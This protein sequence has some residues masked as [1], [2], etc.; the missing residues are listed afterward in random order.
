MTGAAQ[1]SGATYTIMLPTP[2]SYKISCKTNNIYIK[3]GLPEGRRDACKPQ[4]PDAA[5]ASPTIAL[6]PLDLT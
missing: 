1:Q 3:F 5:N 2:E 6:M 4:S